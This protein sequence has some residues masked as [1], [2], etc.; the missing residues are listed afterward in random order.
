MA[1]PFATTAVKILSPPLLSKDAFQGTQ[2]ERVP[3]ITCKGDADYSRIRHIK[4]E[5]DNV[6]CHVSR[7][8]P[9]SLQYRQ[10]R[11]ENQQ[12]HYTTTPTLKTNAIASL[13]P[14]RAPRRQ[15]QSLVRARV[16]RKENN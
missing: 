4:T 3:I 6:T 9:P 15:R 8:L 14:Q 16:E 13:M 7:P 5:P 11:I 1:A 12:H 2:Q 10:S